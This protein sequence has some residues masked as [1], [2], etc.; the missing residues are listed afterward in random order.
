M[1][2][3][4]VTSCHQDC[5]R[6]QTIDKFNA[7]FLLSLLAFV[8]VNYAVGNRFRNSKYIYMNILDVFIFLAWFWLSLHSRTNSELH[9]MH[10]YFTNNASLVHTSGE[11]SIYI[12]VYMQHLFAH[13]QTARPSALV[14][15]MY[16]NIYIHI[17]CARQRFMASFRYPNII[18]NIFSQAVAI[19]NR[20]TNTCK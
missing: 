20:N 9:K 18:Q 15:Q 12:Y 7:S 8:I 16:L 13:V 1:K 2:R 19:T 5:R 10:I 14:F 17:Q 3:D 11:S 6:V 4:S